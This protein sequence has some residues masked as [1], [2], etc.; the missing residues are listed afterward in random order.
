MQ[1]FLPLS[2]VVLMPVALMAQGGDF[3]PPCPVGQAAPT[4]CPP[5]FWTTIPGPL[6][7]MTTVFI[8]PDGTNIVGPTSGFPTT[9]SQWAIVNAAN[10]DGSLPPPPAGGPA[11]YPLAGGSTGNLIFAGIPIPAAISF[12]WNYIS[13]ECVMD[14][15]YNDFFTVDII[16]PA[17]GMS[18]ANI[19]YRDTFST[20][21]DPANAVTPDETGTV[22]A[23]FCTTTLEEAPLATA[24]S[25]LFSAPAALVGM[26]ANLEFHVGNSTD[27]GFSSYFYV[28]NIVLAG[29]GAAEYQLNQL[30]ASLLVNGTVGSATAPTIINVSVG[31]TATAVLSSTLI[32]NAWDVGQTVGPLVPGSAGGVTLPDGQIINIDLIDPTFTTIYNP[33]FSGPAWQ[34]SL[35]VGLPTGGLFSVSG[36]FVLVDPTTPSGFRAS[37]ASRLVVQ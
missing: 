25:M 30:E 29:G 26:V 5:E 10:G 32:G 4:G 18:L 16:D 31:G 12:D 17:T 13:P 7:A 35:S 34:G 6:S 23:G 8:E 28:D 11:P 22:P 3:E 14:A 20:T 15:L 24:K 37:Q 36:Q 21:Y 33:A 2:L 1:R 27:A 19:L 9:G